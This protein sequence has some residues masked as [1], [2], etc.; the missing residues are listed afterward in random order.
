[1]SLPTGFSPESG[2]V[3]GDQSRA[4]APPP[5]HVKYIP[6]GEG[7]DHCF[8]SP[9]GKTGGPDGVAVFLFLSL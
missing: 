3:G 4:C 7:V 5:P 6:Q 1:M 2:A 9:V 8:I